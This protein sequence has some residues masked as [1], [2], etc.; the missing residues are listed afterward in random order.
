MRATR[1]A[2]HRSDDGATLRRGRRPPLAEDESATDR[3]EVIR[4]DWRIKE[5]I[6]PVML[7]TRRLLD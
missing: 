1:D 2:M 4:F 5:G 6:Q 3:I 7:V